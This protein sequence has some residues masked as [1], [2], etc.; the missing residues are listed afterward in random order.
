MKKKEITLEMID[1]LPRYYSI[2]SRV[3]KHV[4]ITTG[5]WDKIGQEA[6]KAYNG[7]YDAWR[8]AVIR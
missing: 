4:R 5:W 2:A 8:E 1:R 7:C 6:I 3:H